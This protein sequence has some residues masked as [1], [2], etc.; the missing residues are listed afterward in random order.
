MDTNELQKT[1]TMSMV[2]VELG[3]TRQ[4]KASMPATQVSGF[5][6]VSGLV[7]GHQD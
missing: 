3:G 6:S 2:R 4:Q 5:L 1:Q 7:L